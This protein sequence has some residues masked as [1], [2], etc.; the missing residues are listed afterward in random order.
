MGELEVGGFFEEI[1]DGAGGG[2]GLRAAEEGV[3]GE[4]QVDF[5]DGVEFGEAA[6]ELAAALAVEGA[7]GVMGG[8]VFE[9]MGEI[10]VVADDGGWGGYFGIRFFREEVDGAAGAGE[11]GVLGIEDSGAGGDAAE[12]LDFLIG[13]GE[14]HAIGLKGGAADEEGVDAAAE[15]EK[16]AVVYGRGPAGG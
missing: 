11:Y 6:D 16:A 1:A 9:K 15:I 4:G 14:G 2:D 12:G 7:D 8:E 3:A 5:V 10:S 13:D